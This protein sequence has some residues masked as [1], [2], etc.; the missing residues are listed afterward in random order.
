VWQELPSEADDPVYEHRPSNGSV[1]NHGLELRADKIKNFL[2]I[3][4]QWQ[5]GGFT[6]ARYEDLLNEDN[7]RQLMETIADAF[8]VVP[9]C[10]LT[11]VSSTDA[12]IGNETALPS[13]PGRGEQTSYKSGGG[14]HHHH[15]LNPDFENW[16]TKHTDWET[17]TRIGYKPRPIAK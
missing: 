4:N 13:T 2:D 14:G 1:Y 3:P 16:I 7:M 10:N 5:L 12:D 6:T 17:E 11:V 15:D 8:G 9:V